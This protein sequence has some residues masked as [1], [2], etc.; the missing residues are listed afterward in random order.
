MPGTAFPHTSGH[1]VDT[2]FFLG[3]ALVPSV[4]YAQFV[5]KYEN[6]TTSKKMVAIITLLSMTASQASIKDLQITKI[7][8]FLSTSNGVLRL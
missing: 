6:K 7:S 4:H 8:R 5:Y 3:K 2:G 1:I